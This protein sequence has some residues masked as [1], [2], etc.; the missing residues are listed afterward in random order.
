MARPFAPVPVHTR[1]LVKE[2]EL[3]GLRFTES[4]HAAGSIIQR[5]AHRSATATILLDGSF[6]ER[7]GLH[8]AMACDAPAVHIRPPGE[9]HL[10]RLGAMGAHNLV[11]EVDEARLAGIREQSALFDELH[12]LQAPAVIRL[13]RTIQ[14]ELMMA[15]RASGLTLEG[16]ALQLFGLASRD[17][18]PRHRT[19]PA[20]LE[21]VCEALRDQLDRQDLRIADLA[22]EARVHPVHLARVF[23]AY[24]ET[25]P[26]QYL[27]R[28]RVE[29]AAEQIASSDR[30]L[31]DIAAAVGFADQSH[32]SRVFKAHMGCT[33]GAWRRRNKPA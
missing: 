2:L 24:F 9:P 5:H 20:W 18:A 11:I 14:H 7:Y 16:L 13:A 1:E 26:G 19:P 15:D 23:R 21:R 17:R 25:S 22:A 8:R 33:P 12:H 6:E 28:L 30:P 31:A 32:L 10:D 29:R 4:W 3:G 27:R